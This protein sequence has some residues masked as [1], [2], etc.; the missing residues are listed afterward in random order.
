M[1]NGLASTYLSSNLTMILLRH[2]I[3]I[4]TVQFRSR[5]LCSYPFTHFHVAV[6]VDLI[7]FPLS[8]NRYEMEGN[9]CCTLGSNSLVIRCDRC[10]SVCSRLIALIRG[11][12]YDLVFSLYV[13]YVSCV[14]TCVFTVHRWITY[15]VCMGFSR[16]EKRVG[17]LFSPLK[18]LQN[19]C[20]YVQM[21]KWDGI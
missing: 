6:T 1:Y 13:T 19:E 3:L 8:C 20:L 4:L 10:C 14:S 5:K 9:G 2:H 7:S 12:A 18:R 16:F 17:F 15:N 21:H 11:K